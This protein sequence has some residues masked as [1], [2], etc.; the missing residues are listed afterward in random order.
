M[1]K[2]FFRRKRWKTGLICLQTAIIIIA[3][4]EPIIGGAFVAEEQIA[5]PFEVFYTI[6][7]GDD[8]P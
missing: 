6:F 8:K 5:D 2:F 7:N 3:A 4:L 1:R